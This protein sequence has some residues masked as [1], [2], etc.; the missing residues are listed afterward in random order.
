MIDAFKILFLIIWAVVGVFYRIHLDEQGIE[1]SEEKSRFLTIVS[2]PIIW[3]W[4]IIWFIIS[5][6]I[7]L[8]KVFDKWVKTD[9]AG[10]LSEN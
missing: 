1:I 3:I 2:G 8:F 9:D 10:G 5:G 4:D 6:F 7:P